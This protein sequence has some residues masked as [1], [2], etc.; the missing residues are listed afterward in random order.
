[1]GMCLFLD[2]QPEYPRSVSNAG[3]DLVAHD[4]VLTEAAE[5]LGVQP[6]T[7]FYRVSRAAAISEFGGEEGVE[8]MEQ[9]GYRFSAEQEWFS[10][11]AGLKTAT[12]LR[13][14]VEANPVVLGEEAEE[15]ETVESVVMALQDMAELLQ[16]AEKKQRRF[17]IAY[18]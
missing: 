7:A 9:Q 10:A 17:Y 1:M 14:Y 11:A 4:E 15:D 6:L 13:N 2:S 16:D 12:A 3:K 8:I 5:M 18:H